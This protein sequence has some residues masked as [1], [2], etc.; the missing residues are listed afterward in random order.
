MV[1]E[2]SKGFLVRPASPAD[3]GGIAEAHIASI[4]WLGA[5]G[6]D[7]EIVQDW[8]TGLNANLYRQAME[9]GV[10][11]FVAIEDGPDKR[12]SILGFSSCTYREGKHRTAVYVRGEFARRGIGTALYNRAEGAARRNGASEINIEA[13]TIAAPFY[14]ANGFDELGAGEHVLRSGRKMACVFMRKILIPRDGT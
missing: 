5:Q 11:F 1:A 13:S 9:N 2:T 14:K 8:T 12:A 6:Y 3:V 4:R 7:S 10:V